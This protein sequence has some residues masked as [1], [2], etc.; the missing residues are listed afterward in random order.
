MGLTLLVSFVASLCV[1]VGFAIYEYRSFRREVEERLS[2]F[3][4]LVGTKI[5]LDRQIEEPA[6]TRELHTWLAAQSPVVAAAVFNVRGELALKYLRED[7]S[8]YL[9]IPEPRRAPDSR[10]QEGHLHMF[11]PVLVRGRPHGTVFIQADLRAFRSRLVGYARLVGIIMLAGGLVAVLLAAGLVRHIS[12]PVMNLAETARRVAAEGNYTLRVPV[13]GNDETAVLATEF[14]RMLDCIQQ[15]DHELRQAKQKAEQATQLKSQFLANMSHEIRTPMNGIIGMTELALD[16]QLTAEQ[17]EYLQTVKESADTL[18]ALINDILDFSKIEAGKLE[19]HPVEIALRDELD[20][21]LHTLA[22]RAHQKGLELAVHVLGDVPDSVVADPVRLRQVIVNLVGNAIKFTEKGEVVV[23]VEVRSRT[24]N[25]VQLHFAVRDTGIGI[26]KEKQALIFEAFTQADGSTTRKYGGT[27]LGLSISQQLVRMMGGDIWVESEPGQG[28]T[29]HFTARFPLCA[30]AA[31]SELPNLDLRDLPVL[32]VDDNATNRRILEELLRGWQMRPTVVGS[33]LEALTTLRQAHQDGQ[34][35][36]LV[37]LDYMMP[38]MDGITVANEVLNDPQLSRTPIVLLSSACSSGVAAQS[39]KLGVAGFLTKPIRRSELLNT[40]LT[41][42]SQRWQVTTPTTEK[43]ATSARTAAPRRVLLAEDNPVN[44]RL[45]SRILEKRGHQVVVVDNGKDALCRLERETFDV[46]LMDVQMPRVDGF[47]ATAII[48]E[49]EK[50][51][52]RHQYIIA[53]TAHAMAGDRERCLAAGMDDYISK[54]IDADR[55][56]ELVEQVPVGASNRD[57]AGLT[58]V[59]ESF[60]FDEAL[61]QMEEDRA[62]FAEVVE[63]FR[64]ES[65][66]L[67]RRL[68]EAVDNK[69]A[70]AVEQAAHKLKSSVAIFGRSEA[71]QLVRELEERAAAGDLHD[72]AARLAKLEGALER[73]L[74]ALQAYMANEIQPEE[75]AHE[76]TDSDR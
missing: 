48:R 47:E 53:M 66:E 34:A 18:L 52:G 5:L 8:L 23:T 43:E 75:V 57:A 49:W 32:V 7:V 55:L 30:K 40:I 60:A 72:A 4:D 68:K 21:T 25:E 1:S 76:Q 65:P 74:S 6:V 16:T 28:S 22:F 64:Q 11:Q 35:F 12:R 45:A 33:G 29:F 17:R 44:Q 54:P 42:V 24:E 41:V 13:L 56:I 19:L 61:E 3:A 2:G 27:G 38:D 36:P 63:L 50:Q 10:I 46:V 58:E 15:Q 9:E 51:S 67:V 59:N 71:Q 62:L 20:R 69:E 37:L 73:L 31:E 39:Q 26:P 70:K 14:N